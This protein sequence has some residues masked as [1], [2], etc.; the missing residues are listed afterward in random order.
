MID[1]SAVINL[2]NVNALVLLRNLRDRRFWITQTVADECWPTCGDELTIEIAKGCLSVIDDSHIDAARFLDLLDKHSLGRGETE[3]IVACEDLG[4]SLCCDDKR[5]RLLGRKVLGDGRVAGTMAVLRWFV[6]D[7]IVS[8]EAA[9]GMYREMRAKGG[10]L[11]NV[12]QTDFC[13]S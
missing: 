10:F 1:S 6:A 5:A 7:A 13:S 2:S 12:A 8:A 11:P 4:F 3:S 9:Y